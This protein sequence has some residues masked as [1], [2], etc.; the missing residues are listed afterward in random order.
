MPNWGWLIAALILIDLAVL[1]TW[2]IAR[3][4]PRSA[5]TPTTWVAG[6]DYETR[7]RIERLVADHQRMHAI[8]VLQERSGLGLSD[9][10]AAI[11][12]V[13]RGEWKP[14]AGPDAGPPTPGARTGKWSDLE[15]TLRTLKNEGKAAK[16]IAILRD[17]TGMGLQEATQAVERL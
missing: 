5:R 2:F 12:A 6:L 10:K 4:R 16:A 1:T 8:R 9:A 3:R 7:D 13:V 14:T 15:P 17:S 11:D